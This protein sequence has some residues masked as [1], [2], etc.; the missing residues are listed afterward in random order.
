MW[1]HLENGCQ[2]GS[3][4]GGGVT[5]VQNDTMFAVLVLVLFTVI[6]FVT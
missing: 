1:F 3:D 2:N 5:F 4:G 6:N